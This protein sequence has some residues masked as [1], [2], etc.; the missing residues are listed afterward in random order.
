M[1][2]VVKWYK[3]CFPVAVINPQRVMERLDEIRVKC[4]VA[5]AV[6]KEFGLTLLEGQV[7][8]GFWW[9]GMIG[10]QELSCY[11]TL[12]WL[13]GTAYCRLP[14]GTREKLIVMAL[15]DRWVLEY[16]NA[17]AVVA[18]YDVGEGILNQ[19]YRIVLR[20]HE[21]EKSNDMERV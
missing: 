20:G 3:E 9:D 7:E 10:G 21:G 16:R 8:R 2:D 15:D 18:R 12:G 1:E 4:S 19:N 14:D 13:W 5:R 6:R 11:I 17:S